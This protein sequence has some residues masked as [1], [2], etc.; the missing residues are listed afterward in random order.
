MGICTSNNDIID[1][2]INFNELTT[3]LSINSKYKD[4]FIFKNIVKSDYRAAVSLCREGQKVEL[5]SYETIN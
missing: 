5:I 4:K 1:L 3:Y 2:Y